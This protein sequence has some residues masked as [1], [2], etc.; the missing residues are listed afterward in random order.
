MTGLRS[1]PRATGSSGEAAPLA[2][3]V[4]DA[5][6]RGLTIADEPSA[7]SAAGF[8][9]TGAEAVVGAV[10]LGFDP[11]SG[12]KG[13]TGWALTGVEAGSIDGLFTTGAGPPEDP[14][15][16]ADHPNGAT[17]VDHVVAASP[18]LPRTIHALGQFGIEPRRTRDTDQHGRAMRQVFFRVGRPVLELIGPPEPGG[19]GPASFWGLAL[20]VADLDATKEL[21]GDLLG[22]PKPAVQPDRRIAT[23]RQEPLGITVPLAFMSG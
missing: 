13:I 23:L 7:W 14:D 10:T 21:L 1:G 22:D 16:G 20:A 5:Q 18:D 4:V 2:S 19:S 15:V 12:P 6:L 17:S 11:E 3:T 8:A 9:V